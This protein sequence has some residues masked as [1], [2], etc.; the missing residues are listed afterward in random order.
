MKLLSSDIV[1]GTSLT[2]EVYHH[3]YLMVKWDLLLPAVADDIGCD[4]LRLNNKSSLWS[5]RTWGTLSFSIPRSILLSCPWY[6]SMVCVPRIWIAPFWFLFHWQIFP[7]LLG[8]W[9]KRHLFYEYWPLHEEHTRTISLFG[10]NCF[11][12]FLPN[13]CMWGRK[14]YDKPKKCSLFPWPK[15]SLYEQV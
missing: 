4:I 11:L 12:W 2:V 5:S 13:D 1:V 14:G 6:Q 15:N 10:H 7:F 9:R 8:V 3:Q